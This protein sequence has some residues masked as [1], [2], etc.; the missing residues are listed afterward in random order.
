MEETTERLALDGELGELTRTLGEHVNEVRSKVDHLT[1]RSAHFPG[2]LSFYGYAL[3]VWEGVAATHHLSTTTELGYAAYP[4][5]RAAF[6]AAQDALLL[7]TEADFAAAGARARVFEA[8]EFADLKAGRFEAFGEPDESPPPEGYSEASSS[9]LDDAMK[10]EVD[11]PGGLSLYQAAIDDLLPRF[12]Q[13]RQGRRHPSHWSLRSRRQIALEIGRRV[14]DEA[15]G[16]HLVFTYSQLSRSSHPRLRAESIERRT[17]GPRAQ[18][19][20]RSPRQIRIVV[21]IASVAAG[22]LLKAC[23]RKDARV[24][25]TGTSGG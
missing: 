3:S 7:A 9:L 8:F 11:R 16:K 17:A 6:E 12:L 14:S 19:V 1:I 13:A 23:E 24:W 25:D 15:F 18:F 5:V 10:W 4:I 21:G 20:K 2:D 22:I